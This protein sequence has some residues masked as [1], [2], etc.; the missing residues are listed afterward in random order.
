MQKQLRNGGKPQVWMHFDILRILT[1]R[2]LNTI[3]R[4]KANYSRKSQEIGLTKEFVIL[5]LL[6][7]GL[8]DVPSS[9]VC[10]IFFYKSLAKNV[11]QTL[12]F[13]LERKP[14]ISLGIWMQHNKMSKCIS[15]VTWQTS[16]F[17]TWLTRQWLT[18]AG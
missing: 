7:I 3:I 6:T 8:G 17:S 12:V 5:S 11:K 18:V 10:R 14:Q 16:Y 4:P 9:V 15:N 1:I 13:H 2:T